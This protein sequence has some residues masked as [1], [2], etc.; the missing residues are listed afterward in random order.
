MA[1]AVNA[2]RGMVP[3]E[4]LEERSAAPLTLSRMAVPSRRNKMAS[5]GASF[6]VDF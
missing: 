4:A 1:T 5:L 6:L 2:A 3:I